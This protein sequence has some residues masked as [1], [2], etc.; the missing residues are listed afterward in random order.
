MGD[1]LELRFP[2]YDAYLE[3]WRSTRIPLSGEGERTAER[4]AR[5]QLARYRL[6]LACE[7]KGDAPRARA[8]LQRFLEDWKDAD[9]DVPEVR[10]ARRWLG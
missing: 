6:A 1:A 7:A 5:Y 8:E 3:A 10:D 4:V 9:P 2:S